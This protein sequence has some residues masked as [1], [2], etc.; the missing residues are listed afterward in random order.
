[1]KIFS[2]ALLILCTAHI[3]CAQLHHVTYV[4][5]D[6]LFPNPE[7]GFYSHRE[8]QAEGAP[9][10]LNDLL[11]I[12]SVKN[13]SLILREYY[14]KKFRAIS[15][16]AAQLT[17]IQ[18][19]FNTMR[20]AGV[21]CV[22]RFA[23]SSSET[24][25]DAPLSVVLGHLDQLKPLLQSNSDVIAVMQAS[26]IGA[27]GEWYYS[28]NGL[29]TTAN[30]RAVLLKILDVLPADRMVL[31]R[32]PNYKMDIF[33]ITQP[34][35]AGEAYTGTP[36]ARTGHHN[37]C[38]LSSFDDWGTYQDTSADKA[39]LSKDTRY[40]AMGGETC[41]P[42]EFSSCSNAINESAR[43]HL[44]FL[45]ADYN[46]QVLTP[47][48]TNGCMPE[49]QRRMGY[50]FELIAGDYSD[51]VR[52]GGGFSMHLQLTNKGWASPFNKRLVQLILRRVNDS[53]RYWAELP[54]DPRFWGAGDTVTLG[55]TVGV[56]GPIPPGK[57]DL[58]LALRDPAPAL[59]ARPEF[60][61]RCANAG[62]W[63]SMTGSN[64]LGHVVTIDPGA[65]G[66]E[67]NG[68]IVFQP[69][70]G[71][72]GIN[73]APDVPG[74]LLRLYGNYPNPFNGA[75]RISFT[76]SRQASV[77]LHVFDM[78]GREVY[79]RPEQAFPAGT[80]DFAFDATPLASGSYLYRLTV[81][82]SVANG[83]LLLLK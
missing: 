81:P 53:T 34:L 46:S 73:E 72:T 39:Y 3:A 58:L 25:P 52:P 38:Y 10:T 16:S 23:Y 15:L 42:S 14:L 45:N 30:R 80:N 68:T 8:V 59:T 66:Q 21:K 26:F 6:S 29:N 27:W 40:T 69:V 55:L 65:S 76:L 48:T 12:R 9:L 62:V 78:L 67:Y 5:S 33:S 19:D 41:S 28:T 18:N 79:S 54:D 2:T 22:L 49:I 4:A 61:I 82:G 1:M 32:T 17:L 44:T 70:G 75:T 24:D 51:S 83:R 20:A 43:L 13:Q 74:D 7:R 50:R 57:Y 37:D 60:S 47:W 64:R 56:P 36:V 71:S 31:V 35:S 77:G 11:S 63:E